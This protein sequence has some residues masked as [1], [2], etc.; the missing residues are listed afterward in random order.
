[1]R[2]RLRAVGGPGAV[3]LDLEGPV[4]R[5]TLANA[6]RSNALSGTMLAQLSEAVD[7]LEDW[8]SGLGLVLRG[9]GCRCFC[10]GADLALVRQGLD[11]PGFGR[12]MA[13]WMHALTARLRGLP[14]ISV[15]AIEGAAIGGG[16]ELATV[17]DFR[18]MSR[19]A[20]IRFVHATLGLSPGWGGGG[21]LVE[22]IGRR[23]ALGL[24][25]GARRTDAQQALELGLADRLCPPDE[26][27]ESARAL[28]QAY[29]GLPLASVRAAKSLVAEPARELEL[30]AS[31]WGGPAMRAAIG[32]EG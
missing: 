31:L 9:E 32:V 15:A 26:S 12:A 13:Q 24:L 18:V 10:A 25:A 30:F 7:R 6:A 20:N 1:M 21:R 28:L 4:A 8:D 17:A 3:L 23:Q 14:L 11:D 27:E 5:L 16:A 19:S 22:L 29:E 2:E